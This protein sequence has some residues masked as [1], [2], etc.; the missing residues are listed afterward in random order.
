MTTLSPQPTTASAPPTNRDL[1]TFQRRTPRRDGH[2]ATAAPQHVG[3]IARY[4]TAAPCGPY[5]T[6]PTP[7]N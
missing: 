5:R 1:H 6:K 2:R 7:N 3:N 4:R